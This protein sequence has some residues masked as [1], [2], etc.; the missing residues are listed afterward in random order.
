MVISEV[1]GYEKRQNRN[2]W[3]DEGCQIKVE[4]RNKAQVN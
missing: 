4:A 1:V 2:D 3:Y